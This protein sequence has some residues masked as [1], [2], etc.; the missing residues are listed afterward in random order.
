MNFEPFYTRCQELPDKDRKWVDGFYSTVLR[1]FDDEEPQFQNHVMICS[2]F[3][4][5]HGGVSK[6]QYYRRRIFV[7]MLY[8]W[9]YEQGYVTR[10]TLEYVYSLRLSD[11]V[12]DYE[13]SRY[14]FKNLDEALDFVA[15]VGRANGLDSEDDMLNIKTIVILAWNGLESPEMASIKKRH[16]N[17]VNGTVVIGEKTL[18]IEPKY[19]RVLCKFANIEMHRAFPSCRQQLYVES[20]YLMRSSRQSCMTPNNIRCAIWRFNDIADSY[21]RELSIPHIRRNGVFCKVFESTDERSVNT[22]VQEV[23][24]CDTAFAYGYKEFYTRWKRW[25]IGDDEN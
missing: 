6:A 17:E 10:D 5:D 14:Y 7:R 16:L 24:G 8:D 3:C 21:G 1:T 20:E 2:L 22:L 9:L 23:T 12:T 13:L 15:L 25:T 19:M 4:G 18:H 11:V